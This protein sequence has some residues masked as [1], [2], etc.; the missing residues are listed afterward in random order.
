MASGDELTRRRNERFLGLYRP[1]KADCERWAYSLT[2]DYVVAED[3]L[4][5]SIMVG[6]E[7]LHQLKN[8]GAFKTWMF[9][10]I[11]RNHLLR[12]RADKR[13]ATPVDPEGLGSIRQE[14]ED[15][16]KADQRRKV[17]TI[18]L[19]RLSPEQSQALVLFEM[20]DLSIREVAQVMEKPEGAVRVL[21]HRARI[22]FAEIFDG[23]EGSSELY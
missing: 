3:I 10:I 17:V 18:I 11:R 7:N 6:L 4:Q 21:L 22:R 23:L 1:V 20:E 8:E 9:R 15:L 14:G 13:Q 5:Q 16:D 12:I 2:R 19:N